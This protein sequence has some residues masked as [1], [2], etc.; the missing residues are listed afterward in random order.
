MRCPKRFRHRP[1]HADLLHVDLWWNGVNVAL[2]PGSFSYNAPPPWDGALAETR[3]H[4]TVTVDGEDQMQRVGR[5][6][7]FPWTEGDPGEI[8]S[9]ATGNVKVWTGS[10]RGYYRLGK[11]VIH[12]RAMVWLA[13]I[14]WVILDDLRGLVSTGQRCVLHWL[15]P[16]SAETDQGGMLRLKLEAGG[17]MLAFEGG[18][19]RGETRW[20]ID[21]ADSQS[22]RGWKSEYYQHRAPATS[23]Q[24]EG[25]GAEVMFWSYVGFASGKVSVQG[26]VM[27]IEN[28]DVR[29]ELWLDRAEA[30]V[31]RRA[32]ES[33][34]EMGVFRL[35][36]G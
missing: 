11:R 22:P 1:A 21:R 17:A 34:E 15:L 24:I 9:T 29:A 4:N 2:D 26:D 16:E 14:G 32:N 19:L 30:R 12:R 28:G 33:I 5:F 23:V 3:F 6:L 18:V 8:L 35:F 13:G 20:S 27:S 31:V 25:Y 10:H 7:W 36:R